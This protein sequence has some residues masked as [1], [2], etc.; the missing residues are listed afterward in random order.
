MIENFS[1]TISTGQPYDPFIKYPSYKS[2]DEFIDVERLRSLEDYIRRRIRRRV[3]EQ[4]DIEFY[5]GPF[6]LKEAD[7]HLPGSRMVY[8]AESERSDSYFDLDC[9]DLWRPTE[10]ANEFVLLMD[11]IATL[12]FKATGRMLIIY[13]EAGREVPAHRDHTATD[14][15]HDFIWMRTN[16]EKPFFVLNYQT[17]EREYVAGYS[18]WFDTV[19]QFHGSDATGELSFSIR[20]D[21]KFT[22]EFAAMI[23]HPT[24]NAASKPSF[25][26]S[27]G[28]TNK[29][30]K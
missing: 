21:G 17:G 23:P 27:L 8:L 15:L 9:T 10:A 2:F 19:N 22:D 11:F 13:D 4:S 5:T 28:N 3:L 14:V 1:D 25:W 16:L 12:P 7:D 18:A 20:A 30:E 26:A 29:V 24:F 6:K